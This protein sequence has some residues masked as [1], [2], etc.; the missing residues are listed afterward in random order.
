MCLGLEGAA[1]AQAINRVLCRPSLR[2]PLANGCF[3]REWDVRIRAPQR[4]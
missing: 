4:V 1:Q 3:R 2:P